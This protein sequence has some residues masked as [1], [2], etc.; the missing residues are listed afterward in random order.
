MTRKDEVARPGPAEALDVAAV[1]VSLL[2]V[3][4]VHGVHDVLLPVLG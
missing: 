2:L 4:V 3:V 1:E